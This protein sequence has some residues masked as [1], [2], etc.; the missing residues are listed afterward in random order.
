M[1]RTAA[2]ADLHIQECMCEC[3]DD[4]MD[5]MELISYDY[6]Y[7][8]DDEWDEQWDEDDYNYEL[9]CLAYDNY[10]HETMDC[11]PCEPVQTW[12]DGNRPGTIF[13]MA[14]E[15]VESWREWMYSEGQCPCPITRTAAEH[16]VNVGD[17]YEGKWS[18]KIV[19]EVPNYKE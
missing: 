3:V 18:L 2:A 12:M 5:D 16:M 10:L 14:E 6:G 1:I 17:K 15:I 4:S 11:E 19:T 13:V 8:D 7:H 9:E